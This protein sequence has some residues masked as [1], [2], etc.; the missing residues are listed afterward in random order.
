[1]REG[2]G[3]RLAQ[4]S[5]Q[6]WWVL[7]GRTGEGTEEGSLVAKPVST[8]AGGENLFTRF[9]LPV[10]LKGQLCFMPWGSFV[11]LITI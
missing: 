4:R 6:G 1:M 5:Q 7:A 8:G 10:K 2:G 9:N 11:I 3:R